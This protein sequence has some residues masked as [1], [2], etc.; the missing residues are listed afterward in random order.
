MSNEFIHVMV[1]ATLKEIIVDKKIP[2][3]LM[4]TVT[5]SDC[6]GEG[7]YRSIH[8]RKMIS[9]PAC[10]GK[11]AVQ[12]KKKHEMQLTPG[13]MDSSG[14]DSD[15]LSYQ[16]KNFIQGK[17]IAVKVNIEPNPLFTP[18]GKDLICYVP[19]DDF[20]P[21]VKRR[22]SFPTLE[23]PFRVEEIILGQYDEYTTKGGGGYLN[24]DPKRGD[25]IYQ[26]IRREDRLGVPN[27][28]SAPPQKGHEEDQSKRTAR[29]EES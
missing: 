17:T 15:T 24:D 6:H 2:F 18:M 3:E 25:I 10:Q 16:I 14:I 1:N 23:N 5:C 9:C 21:G 12:K 8:Y 29:T 26:L 20:K 4:H 28:S 7:N 13:Y 27:I 22:L 11:G 19:I